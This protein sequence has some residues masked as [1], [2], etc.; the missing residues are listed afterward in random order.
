MSAV[1]RLD[2]LAEAHPEWMAWLRVLREVAPELSHPRWD[3]GMPQPASAAA[4]AA[5]DFAPVLADSHLQPDGPALARL[6]SRLT[7]VARAQGLHAMA[8]DG[9][10]LGAASA[11]DALAIFIA[12]LADDTATL[13]L[14]AARAGASP[15]GWRTLAQW[16]PMPYLHACARRWAA[17]PAR[18]AWSQ[19]Y[20]PVCGAWPALA[21]ARGVERSRHLRCGRCGAGWP[22][23]VLSC[24]YCA[25]TDHETL[26]TLVVDDRKSRFS[27]DV[28]H[29]CSGY[30]KSFTTLQATP[31]D[32]ILAVD[33]E[34]VE[35]DLAAVEL[36][37]RRPLGPGA[38]LSASLMADPA[39]PSARRG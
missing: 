28:C 34:S 13:D 18:P 38:A 27:V 3:G 8:G 9:K 23:P 37:F 5:A 14:Q 31:S 16:L 26:G 20:C 4:A 24:T 2:A 25:T 7:G 33:L 35:F 32:E 1:S 15:Q 12:A 21:E 22:M 10:G 19:G 11:D 39:P 6:W 29:G 17:N 36:G 30:L